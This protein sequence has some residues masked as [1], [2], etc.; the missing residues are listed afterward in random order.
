MFADSRKYP[1]NT[2]RGMYHQEQQLAK[3]EEA[4]L[5]ITNYDLCQDHTIISCNKCGEPT[6]HEAVD[7]RGYC[8]D[9]SCE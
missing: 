4:G 7:V 9:C 1:M 6:P 8:P 2:I 5:L 3:A